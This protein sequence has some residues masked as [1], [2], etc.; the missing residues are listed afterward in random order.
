MLNWL[1]TY[2]N[3]RNDLIV[4]NLPFLM[5]LVL[6]AILYIGNN[7]FGE[8]MIRRTHQMETQFKEIRWEYMSIKSELM[9][10]SKQSHVAK[11]VSPLGL[12]ELTE[13]PKKIVIRDHGN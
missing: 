13:P 10:K 2:T 1:D 4:Q 5:F 8:K 6:L 11:L 9:F 3:L 12:K 7:H